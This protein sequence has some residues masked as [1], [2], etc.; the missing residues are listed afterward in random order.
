MAINGGAGP[1]MAMSGGKEVEKRAELRVFLLL[2]VV[3]APLISV[4][5]VGGLGFSIWIF[6]L[7][8]GPPGPPH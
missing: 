5:L 2:A 1:T 4:L 7:V 6:Q 3:L 8:A